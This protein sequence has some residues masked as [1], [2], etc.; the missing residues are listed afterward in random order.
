LRQGSM[1]INSKPNLFLL[2]NHTLTAPQETDACISLGVKS[3]VLPPPEI[4]RLWQEIPP[5]SEELLS[6]LSPV[7]TWLGNEPHPGD[8]VLIQGEFGATFLM[9]NEALRLG[10]VPVYST[11][12]RKAIEQLLPDGQV[13]ISH[14][15]SHVRY[16]KYKFSI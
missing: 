11:T 8:F 7:F 4:N 5:D 12:S 2:F 9:V 15:F 10:L 14:I 13:K 3:I 1:N 6:Y 16:R